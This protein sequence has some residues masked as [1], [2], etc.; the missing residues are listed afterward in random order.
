[1]Q[2]AFHGQEVEISHNAIPINGLS[3]SEQCHQL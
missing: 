2:I 1:V 3:H